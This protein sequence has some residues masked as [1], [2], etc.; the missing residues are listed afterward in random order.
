[1]ACL[2]ITMWL[3]NRPAMGTKQTLGIFCG[4]L[5]SW[6]RWAV[7]PRRGDHR[8]SVASVAVESGR[9][10]CVRVMGETVPGILFYVMRLWTLFVD[11]STR[12]V[13]GFGAFIMGG[14]FD[15]CRRS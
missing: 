9:R 13:V 7:L 4:S 3:R 5:V 10:G 11:F 12:L 8:N 14:A 15:T 1:M 2:L 6:M